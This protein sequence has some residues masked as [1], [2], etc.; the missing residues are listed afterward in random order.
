MSN[1]RVAN[2]FCDDN[3]F[4]D[5][6]CEVIV[7][8]FVR[9]ATDICS[10]QSL[11]HCRILGESDNNFKSMWKQQRL[12]FQ[13]SFNRIEQGIKF[14]IFTISNWHNSQF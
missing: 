2:N 6:W 14:T 7:N 1:L 8:D 11:R 5:S 9:A 12:Q 3:N 13:S 4:C 10:C